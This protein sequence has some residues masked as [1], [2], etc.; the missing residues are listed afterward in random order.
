[1]KKIFLGVISI[2]LSILTIFTISGCSK[3]D[4]DHKHNYSSLFNYSS[5]EHWH[6]CSC[7]EKSEVAYHTYG[8]WIIVKD[9]KHTE[10]GSKKQVCSVCGYEK[11]ETIPAIGHSFAT[12]WSSDA[13]SHWHECS[14]GEKSEVAS[15]TYGEWIIVKDATEESTGSKKL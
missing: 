7:G 12:N 3:K 2:L 11:T 10:T 14:C 5:Y 4:E 8:E 15:H 13:A 1:M 6:E 9:A